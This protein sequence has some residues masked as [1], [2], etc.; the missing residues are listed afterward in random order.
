MRIVELIIDENDEHSGIDAISIVESPAIEENF[1]ALNKQKEYKFAKVDDEKRLLM[2]AI[3]VPNKPIYRK[4]GEDEYYIYF[5]KDTVRKASELY[6]MKGNQSNA[7]YE[8]FEKIN[9]LSLV[10]SWIVEDKQKDKTSLYGMDLPLGTWAGSIKVNND[11]VW[12]EFVKTGMVKGFSIE[13]YFADKAERPKEQIGEDLSSE[14]EAG[15]KLL[16][17]KKDMIIYQ[18]ET[19]NDYPEAASNNAKRAIKYKEENDVKCGTRIGWTRAR[20]L[21]D[22]ERI[23]RDTIARMASFNR[24]KQNSKVPYDEGCGGIM[25]DAW[26]G[27]TGINWAINKMKTFK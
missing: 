10:E 6:L 19:F 14:I 1:V 4:D 5:T 24:H 13:G 9:G 17:I 21:A 8:H 22:K 11:Q 23:S 25:W 18:L 2:G 27:T 7:T 15:K 3:L 12:Q 26:G 16:S 20:Q